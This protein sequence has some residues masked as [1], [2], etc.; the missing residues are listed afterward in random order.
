MPNFSWVS[1]IPD[2]SIDLY[3]AITGFAAS[4]PEWVRGLVE[5]GTDAGLVVFALCFLFLF[6]RARGRGPQALAAALAIPLAVA[7]SYLVSEAL[8]LLLR[9]DRPCRAVPGAAVITEC[10]PL[11][12]WSFPSNHSTLAAA[13]A[14]ALSCVWLRAVWW[15]LPL[16]ALLA[17][18]RVFLGVHYP[19]DV[20]AGFALGAV[21]APALVWLG[22]RALTPVLTRWVQSRPRTSP[23]S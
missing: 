7:G 10:P 20:L 15:L 23:A 3:R 19:H 4:T 11:G 13:F 12:D 9:E 18:S 8:K 21:L 5:F 16:A 1:L 14:L 2:V 22:G 17:A 6:W